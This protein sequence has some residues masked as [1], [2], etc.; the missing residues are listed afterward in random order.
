MKKLLFLGAFLFVATF[1]YGQIGI[2]A[3]YTSSKAK[4]SGDGV[5]ISSEDATGAFSIGLFADLEIDSSIDFQTYVSYGIG[6]KVEDESNTA[7]GFG[8]NF[9]FYPMGRENGF[10]LRGGVGIGISL[11][12]VDTDFIKKSATSGVLGLGLDVSENAA[13]ILG[14][15]A[16]LSDSSNISGIQIKASGIGAQLQV[17]F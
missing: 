8:G 5:S 3:G 2:S 7:I 15:S 16:Q 11:M 14:Y 9:D 6:E 4:I 10:F 12:D 17:K 1:S 13:I